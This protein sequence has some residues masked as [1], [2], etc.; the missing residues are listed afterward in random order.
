MWIQLKNKREQNFP[1]NNSKKAF[2]CKCANPRILVI[3]SLTS[4]GIWQRC[5]SLSCIPWCYLPVVRMQCSLMWAPPSFYWG[6]DRNENTVGNISTEFTKTVKSYSRYGW[7]RT[8]QMKCIWNSFM[9]QQLCS[10]E[11]I[12]QEATSSDCHNSLWLHVKYEL[13]LS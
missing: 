4:N 13:L 10:R 12:K 7:N 8:V 11:G 2:L 1:Q 3:H 5:G 9:W 6:E